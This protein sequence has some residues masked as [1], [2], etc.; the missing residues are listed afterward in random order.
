MTTWNNERTDAY[1]DNQKSLDRIS[2]ARADSLK[3]R[4]PFDNVDLGT[5][6]Q[7]HLRKMLI[8]PTT[9]GLHDRLPDINRLYQKRRLHPK[10]RCATLPPADRNPDVI[11]TYFHRVK[12]IFHEMGGSVV[13]VDELNDYIKGSP[14][15]VN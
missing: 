7:R 5:F 10:K 1:K 13:F 11:S 2:N 9:C 4:I 12:R 6:S 14:H 8:H 3:T 15:Q